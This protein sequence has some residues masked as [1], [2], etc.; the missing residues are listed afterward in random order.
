LESPL[1]AQF[2]ITNDTIKKIACESANM[3]VYVSRDCGHMYMIYEDTSIWDPGSTD[4]SIVIDTVAH[5]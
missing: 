3:E 5:T 1:K 4:T 2:M